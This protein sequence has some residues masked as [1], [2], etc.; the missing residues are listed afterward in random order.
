MVVLVAMALLVV[1]IVV[2]LVTMTLLVVVIMVMVLM[3]MTLLV[4]VIVVVVLVAMALLIVIVIVVVVLM[5]FLK[6]LYGVRKGVAAFHCGENI[7]AVKII[8]RGGHD[9]GIG[10]VLAKK[11]NALGDLMILGVLSM[12]KNDCR[13]VRDLI[14]IE[15]AKV[16][17]IH[18][19]LINVGNGREGIES[20]ILTLDGFGGTDNVRKLTNARGLDNNAVGIVLF[21]HLCQC[22]RKIA[23]KRA[24]NASRIHL[25]DLNTG[26]GKEAAVDRNVAEFVFYENYLFTGVSLFDQLLYKCGFPGAEESGEYVDF[27]HFQYSCVIKYLYIIIIPQNISRVKF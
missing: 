5:L 17:H 8:P 23:D 3:T 15:L 24:A 21:E 14:V 1:V 16:L 27:R 10:V 26:I 7:L 20:G 4:I 2:V 13:G 18:F 22:L 12:R 9:S 11:L 19:A 6:R 25:G